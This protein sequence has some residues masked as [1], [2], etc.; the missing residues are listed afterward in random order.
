MLG[1]P[2]NVLS[3]GVE[4]GTQEAKCIHFY[5]FLTIEGAGMY[6]M[7]RLPVNDFLI[8]KLMKAECV[9]IRLIPRGGDR[10]TII[11]GKT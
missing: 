6:L 8:T 1:I 9:S 11:K 4:V 5:A 2:F 10:P 7:I 3:G